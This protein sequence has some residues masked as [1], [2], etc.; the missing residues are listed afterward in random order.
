MF[1]R[2]FNSKRLLRR[3]ESLAGELLLHKRL[4]WLFR[5]QQ[6]PSGKTS[7]K[8]KEIN[9]NNDWKHRGCEIRG[10]GRHWREASAR[11]DSRRILSHIAV[12]LPRFFFFLFHRT[13]SQ[14]DRPLLVK[15]LMPLQLMLTTLFGRRNQERDGRKRSWL[16][17]RKQRTRAQ[18]NRRPK[19]YRYGSIDIEGG[20][21]D[22]VRRA[23]VKLVSHIK[24]L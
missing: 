22:R 3:A 19:P 9:R 13:Q 16:P 11:S 20:N 18:L 14:R 5:F 15:G 24:P 23:R 2:F 4:V 12:F 7:N 17:K 8:E 21:W 10:G 1:L 6:K